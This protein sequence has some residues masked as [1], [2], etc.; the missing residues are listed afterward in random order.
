MIDVVKFNECDSDWLVRCVSFLITVKVILPIDD[1]PFVIE[2]LIASL[3]V[4]VVV[5]V[6]FTTE[7]GHSIDVVAADL[8]IGNMRETRGHNPHTTAFVTYRDVQELNEIPIRQRK[9]RM[10]VQNA[11]KFGFYAFFYVSCRNYFFP[12]F[13]LAVNKFAETDLTCIHTNP[14]TALLLH[15]LP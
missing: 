1:L 12:V 11:V 8:V 6:I 13:H 15:Q 3:V 5:C 14:P 2:I 9:Y 10:T 7:Y 4:E